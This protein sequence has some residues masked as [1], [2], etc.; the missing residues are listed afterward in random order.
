VQ[1]LH[2]ELELT[3]TAPA[4]YLHSILLSNG[5]EVRLPFKDV[6]VEQAHALIPAPRDGQAGAAAPTVSQPA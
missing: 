4:A 1:W 2:D 6:R 3:A 5:W